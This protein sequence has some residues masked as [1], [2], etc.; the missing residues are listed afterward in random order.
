[1]ERLKRAVL[2]L[3]NNPD[4]EH[5]HD[6]LSPAHHRLA[7]VIDGE[8]VGEVPVSRVAVTLDCRDGRPMLSLDVLVGSFAEVSLDH[9]LP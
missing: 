8:V 1:M 3:E 6:R 7:V 9:R 4:A 2:R 5:P